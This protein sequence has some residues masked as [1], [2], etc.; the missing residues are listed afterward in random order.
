MPAV[1]LS[2][3]HGESVDVLVQ[4]FE[5]TD[6]LNDGLILPVHVQRNLVP[7]EGVA[8][9]EPGLLEVIIEELLGLEEADEVG[10]EPPHELQHDGR[11]GGLDFKGLSKGAG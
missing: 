6:R 5:Q 2:D 3:S 4:E 10:P 9:T 7:G 8:E 11:G 1:P